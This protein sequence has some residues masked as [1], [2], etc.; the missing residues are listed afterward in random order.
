[1]KWQ[2]SASQTGNKSQDHV[3]L[4]RGLLSISVSELWSR[5]FSYQALRFSEA[6][7]IWGW[8]QKERSGVCKHPDSRALQTMV[9][10]HI[11]SG[12]APAHLALGVQVPRVEEQDCSGKVQSQSGAFSGETFQPLD[13]PRGSPRPPHQPDEAIWMGLGVSGL[14]LPPGLVQRTLLAKTREQLPLWSPWQRN[15]M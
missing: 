9:D 10:D 15:P 8:F 14:S 12:S 2:W 13:Q 5:E 4:G 7:A 11:S 1:M 6:A 3:A